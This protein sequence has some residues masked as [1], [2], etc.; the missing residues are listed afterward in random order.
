MES[1]FHVLFFPFMAKGHTLPLL[2]LIHLLRRRF[3]HLSVTLFTTAANRPF[4]SQFLLDSDTDSISIINLSFPQNVPGL[5]AGVESTDTLPSISLFPDLWAATELMQPEFE[6]QLQ[7]LPHPVTFLISD[8]FLWWTVESASKFGI[9]R[10]N[11]SGMSNFNRAILGSIYQNK[12]FDGV[13][14]SDELIT[15]TDFPWVKFVLDDLDEVFWHADRRTSLHFQVITKSVH[16]ATNSYGL[17]VNSFYELESMFCD[18]IRNR[19]M[20]MIWNIGP[21]C[22]A[23]TSTQKLQTQQPN[24][25]GTWLEWLDAKLRR[26]EPVLYVAFGSQAE[27]SSEQTKEIEIGLEESGVSFLWARK[28]KEIGDGFE[29]RVKER[30]IVVREWVDQWEVLNHGSVKGFL[31]H[32]GWN[33]VVES[34][35]CGVP[36]LAFPL[37]ADQAM[38]ARM[39]VDELRAGMRTAECEGLVKGFVKGKGLQRLVRELMEG[40]KGKEVRKRAMEIS[41]MAKK[42]MAENGSS[43]RDLEQLVQEMCSNKL[44]LPHTVLAAPSGDG[45]NNV[46]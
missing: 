27:I 29:E 19:E 1:A 11:F 32:C 34:L 40:E 4:I 3:P 38:N 36:V 35:S 2:H 41:A 23:Q 24:K 37:M 5:P 20:G 7:S 44:P 26:G 31:S 10:I 21:L 45:I 18:Y 14:S 16:A 39:V 25:T 46:H 43:W 13:K 9:P 42:A 28:D 17:I 30:G 22:L 33:S 6:K 15:V 12:L 8:M